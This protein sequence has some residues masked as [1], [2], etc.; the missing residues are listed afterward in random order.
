MKKKF[1]LRALVFLMVLLCASTAFAT[2]F[3]DMTGTWT[4]KVV[5]SDAVEGMEPIQVGLEGKLKVTQSE[6]SYTF[7]WEDGEV[8]VFVVKGDIL[9]REYSK[10]NDD[11]VRVNHRVELTYNS[12]S[13]TIT[14]NEYTDRFGWGWKET[15]VIELV[16]SSENGGKSSTITQTQSESTSDKVIETVNKVVETIVKKISEIFAN[17]PSE[18]EKTIIKL[19]GDNS[20]T[21][22][23]EFRPEE[24]MGTIANNEKNPVVLETMS[25]KTSGIYMF[26]VPEDNLTAGTKIYI[27]MLVDDSV[28]LGSVKV[29]E[30][31]AKSA[32]FVNDSGEVIDTV[33]ATLDVNVAAYMAAN[34]AYTPVVT[35]EADTTGSKNNSGNND[36]GVSSSG[37]GCNA[38][39]GIFGLLPVALIKKLKK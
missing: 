1:F 24:I 32:V 37:D 3:T 34:T 27:H 39:L 19:N 9:V 10:A 26:K 25:V 29:A 17:L 2:D 38:G 13:R 12:L 22:R 15:W 35:Q 5:S 11:G 31:D 30:K 23:R 28:V 21:K 7:T 18:I 14:F 16:S 8:E 6:N 20:T 36:N 4:A 33:P